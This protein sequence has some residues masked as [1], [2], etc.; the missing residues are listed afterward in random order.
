MDIV[1]TASS[2]NDPVLFGEWLREGTHV[3]AI[4]ATTVFRRELDEEAVARANVVV[5][6]HLP[7]AEAELGELLYAESHGK[8]RWSL[9]RELKDIVGCVI[10][11]RSAPGDIT[12]FDSIGVGT[13]DV[14]V[15]AHLLQK[16]RS[17]S[18]GA[19]LPI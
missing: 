15:A 2:A 18:I 7:Q 1:V 6:E 4:G 11:G 17:L 5:V 19:E 14:A 3:N 13:E 9:V 10:P 8:L 16:A 12:L